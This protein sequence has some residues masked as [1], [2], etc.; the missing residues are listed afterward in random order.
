MWT[1]R[2]RLHLRFGERIRLNFYP[3]LSLIP[4]RHPYPALFNVSTVLDVFYFIQ[5]IFQFWNRERWFYLERFSFPKRHCLLATQGPFI[6]PT[7]KDRFLLK[8]ILETVKIVH[9]TLIPPARSVERSK[10]LMLYMTN[11]SF[12][13]PLLPKLLKKLN[14]FLLESIFEFLSNFPQ[15]PPQL[16]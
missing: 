10:I 16:I 9:G 8:T 11:G 5:L 1:E 2:I 6:R 15:G 7:L 3:N 4:F 14:Y 13:P 12:L